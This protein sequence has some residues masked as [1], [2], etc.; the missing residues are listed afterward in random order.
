[1]H[2]SRHML[3]PI[4]LLASGS[5][6]L[7]LLCHGLETGIEL[8]SG[9]ERSHDHVPA[10]MALRVIPVVTDDVTPHTVVLG[11]NPGHD[12]K[13]RIAQDANPARQRR[14]PAES[15]T[16]HRPSELATHGD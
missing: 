13:S 4:N 8:P 6:S 16:Q 14:E 2:G 3:T 7:Y 9:I 12:V 15:G 1:M 10:L 11:V 5:A